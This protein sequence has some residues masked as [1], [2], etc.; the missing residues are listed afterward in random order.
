MCFFVVT[1][2]D[3]ND[4]SLLAPAANVALGRGLG[5]VE[6]GGQLLEGLRGEHSR[7]AGEEMFFALG[8]LGSGL[9]EL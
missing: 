1:L 8:A 7:E 3:S 6:A 2:F 5:D 9:G 4:D